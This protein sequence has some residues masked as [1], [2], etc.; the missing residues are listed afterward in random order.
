MPSA[1]GKT[2]GIKA[3]GNAIMVKEERDAGAVALDGYP[4]IS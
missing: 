4:P 3:G 2:V 1:W